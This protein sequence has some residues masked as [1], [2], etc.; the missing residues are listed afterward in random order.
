MKNGGLVIFS[1]FEPLARV[2]SLLINTRI[3]LF[4]ILC[5]FLSYVLYYLFIFNQILE[6]KMYLKYIAS[7]YVVAL[8]FRNANLKVYLKMTVG[9]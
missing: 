9:P 4:I 3:V 7:D 6:I 2:S 5:V 8:L 1:F